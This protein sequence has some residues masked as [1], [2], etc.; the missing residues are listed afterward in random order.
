MHGDQKLMESNIPVVGGE[1]PIQEAQEA[2]APHA[3]TANG[4]AE[5]SYSPVSAVEHS[6]ADDIPAT[7]ESQPTPDSM[8]AMLDQQ[9]SALKKGDIIEGTVAQTTPT[10]ILVDIGLKSEGVISGK[11]LERMDRETLESLKVGE[12]VLAYV[13]IPEDKNGNVVLS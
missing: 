3:E 7:D 13:L 11:E 10:E 9:E 12:K 4:A 1:E 8:E 5:Q 6:A 2:A